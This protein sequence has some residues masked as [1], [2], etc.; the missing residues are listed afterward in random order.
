MGIGGAAQPYFTRF[1]ETPATSATFPYK[2]FRVGVGISA[3]PQ[4]EYDFF[5]RFF[6]NLSSPLEIF[7]ISLLSYGYEN[8]IVPEAE[9]YTKE[10]NLDLFPRRYHLR[11]GLGVRF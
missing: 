3:I 4:I 2:S 10:A 5:K 11:M 7:D 9:R 8:P 1:K 6:I